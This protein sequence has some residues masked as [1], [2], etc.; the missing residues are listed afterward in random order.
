MKLRD[1]RIGWR[2]LIQE[3]AYSAVV[4]FGLALGF[5]VCFLL[6]GFVR[7]SFDYNKH[8]PDADRV[9]VIKSIFHF[10]GMEPNWGA[11]SS[12]AARNAVL[13]AGLP[14][15]ATAFIPQAGT[16]VRVGDVV[17]AVDFVM[18]DPSFTKVFGVKALAGDL[19]ATL[20]RPDT[21]ALTQETA[22]RLFQD[23][24]VLGRTLQVNGKTHTVTAIVADPPANTTTPYAA[25]ANVKGSIFPDEARES[26]EENWGSMS[27]AVYLRL[28]PGLQPAIVAKSLNDALG[29]SPWHTAIPAEMK[30]S[31]NGTNMIE[32]QLGALADAYLDPQVAATAD[33][34]THG[35]QKTILGLAATGL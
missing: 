3:P 2:L 20:A 6:L 19:D 4:V 27:G 12:L 10:P 24:N 15:Q 32:M 23:V 21:I 18:V 31:L 25:L 1:F 30:R 11:A 16:S 28:Q 14:L 26:T 8:V 22:L 17:S 29:R 35:D 9:F 13:T 7:Y 5:A 34:N 33:P